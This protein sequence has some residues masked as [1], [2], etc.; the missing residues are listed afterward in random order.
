M[1]D[2]MFED[3]DE[4][5]ADTD[6]DLRLI[7]LMLAAENRAEEECWLEMARRAYAFAKGADD[8]D[9]VIRFIPDGP[10]PFNAV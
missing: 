7:C 1:F 3:D 10:P 4:P 2:A 5:I 6:M 8:G 9:N